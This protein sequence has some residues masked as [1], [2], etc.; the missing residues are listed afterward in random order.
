MVSLARWW[1]SVEK[2]DCRGY[3]ALP[4]LYVRVLMALAADVA[5]V[6]NVFFWMLPLSLP[7]PLPLA[8]SL[9]P[10]HLLPLPM[11]LLLL[12]HHPA[13]TA[14]GTAIAPLCICEILLCSRPS[15]RLTACC[16]LLI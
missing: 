14:I 7:F 4:L 8:L 3:P 12:L 5:A 9:P 16:A 6:L 11:L 13:A 10:R 15:F 2:P 1:P